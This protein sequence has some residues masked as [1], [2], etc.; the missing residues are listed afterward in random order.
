M[1]VTAE[2]NQIL[3]DLF[4]KEFLPCSHG[5]RPNRG[6]P[7]FFAALSKCGCGK[8][9]RLIKADLVMC[10]DLI[11][12]DLLLSILRKKVGEENI[13]IIKLVQ[14]FLGFKICG[15]DYSNHSRGIPQ[16]SPLS[17]LLMNVFLH[18]LDI[19]VGGPCERS[20]RN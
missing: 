19:R 16:G 17:P 9:D 5:F 20:E 7:T 11:D 15:K 14:S 3:S 12:H 8:V 4:E 10:F 13:A 2:L 18:Q 6:M 1:A